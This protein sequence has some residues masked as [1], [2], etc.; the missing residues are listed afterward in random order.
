M[1]FLEAIKL[2]FESSKNYKNAI[3]MEILGSLFTL[4][5]LVLI[6][7]VLLK[8]G[9]LKGYDLKSIIVYYLFINFLAILYGFAGGFIPPV[10]SR[11]IMS[12]EIKDYL[13]RPFNFLYY[14]IFFNFGKSVVSFG[15][16][17]LLFVL[18]FLF[19]K[20]SFLD[21]A[22]LLFI[23]LISTIFFILIRSAV[24]LLAFWLEDVSVLAML[25]YFFIMILSGRIIPL[26]FY[27]NW[28]LKII[29][30]LPFKYMYYLPS[31]Y[32]AS[33]ISSVEI[34]KGLIILMFW[35]LIF[36]LIDK[37]LFNQGIKKL[38]AYGG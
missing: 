36:A 29:D 17:F 30:W 4:I 38:K 13:V 9:S 19:F 37:W 24:G 12:G 26:D 32:F 28:L 10:L 20:G 34:I 11:L 5:F 14:F 27:P 33:K 22:V 25:V 23:I 1:L 18:F 16:V 6:W 35:S 3:L 7:S 21:L 15:L 8:G 31:A 2:R